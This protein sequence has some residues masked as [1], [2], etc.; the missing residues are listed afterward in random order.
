[1]ALELY[2]ERI[3]ALKALVTGSHLAENHVDHSAGLAE[4]LHNLSSLQQ[5]FDH[6]ADNLLTISAGALE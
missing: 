1:L 3:A 5:R 4:F 6:E 2:A